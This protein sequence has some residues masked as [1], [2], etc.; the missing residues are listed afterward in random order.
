MKGVYL[1]VMHLG[2]R[3]FIKIGSLGGIEFK[4]GYYAYT[5]S[6]MGGLEQRI[7]RH[8]REEKKLHWHIDY[9][10]Q[11]ARIIACYMKE[12]GSK[13]EECRTAASLQSAG[14]GLVPGFGCSDCNCHTHLFHFK[15]KSSITDI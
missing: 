1:L 7:S 4:K 3:S 15:N 11:K 6:A 12:T 14:G 8:L 5:G 2:A 13:H 9:F 10:L